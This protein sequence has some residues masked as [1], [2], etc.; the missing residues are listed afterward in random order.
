MCSFV[1]QRFSVRHLDTDQAFRSS[2]S[3]SRCFAG[4]PFSPT[5]V[6]RGGLR[7]TAAFDGCNGDLSTRYFDAP[8]VLR[9]TAQR[10]Q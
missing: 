1:A 7:G 2:T 3:V 6:T 9:P 8:S 4:I 5:L 10:G